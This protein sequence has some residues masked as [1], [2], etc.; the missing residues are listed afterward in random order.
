MTASTQQSHLRKKNFQIEFLYYLV[1]SEH[2]QS[3][4]VKLRTVH[5]ES[6]FLTETEISKIFT[7]IFVQV[8][9]I[10]LSDYHIL[11][12]I[13]RA[14]SFSQSLHFED[15]YFRFDVSFWHKMAPESLTCFDTRQ[16]IAEFTT[17]G[18]FSFQPIWYVDNILDE[19]ETI[20]SIRW[21]IRQG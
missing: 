7:K 21:R 2:F 15:V 20:K 9:P 5:S 17:L 1:Y 19:L 18:T 13:I 16:L 14:T 8:W 12:Y 6:S 3:S 10:Q 4:V 11:W